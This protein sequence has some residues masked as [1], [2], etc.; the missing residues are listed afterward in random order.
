MKLFLYTT[1]TQITDQDF[2]DNAG[3]LNRT[4]TPMAENSSLLP[5]FFQE[6][7]FLKVAHELKLFIYIYR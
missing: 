2:L 1:T 5:D 7:K 6:T 3:D 4:L